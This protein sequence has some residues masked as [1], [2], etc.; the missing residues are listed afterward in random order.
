[1]AR[2]RKQVAEAVAEAAKAGEAKTGGR[3]P[4]GRLSDVF[5]GEIRRRDVFPLLVLHLIAKDPTYGNHLIEEIEEI[6]QGVIS[7]NP[8]TMYPLLREMESKGL[9]EGRWEHPDRR[10]R[11]FYSI[12]K[13]GR[14]EQKRLV[15]EVEP[16][17]DSVIRS[18]TLIKSEIYGEDA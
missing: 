15:A 5:G 13:N 8:N 16:F 10:T 1:M 12:T 14:R 18:V 3:K 9:I 2:E 7:V 11:R 6:T 17:L 4:R